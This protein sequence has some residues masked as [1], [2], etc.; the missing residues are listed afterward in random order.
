MPP[1]ARPTRPRHPWRRVASTSWRSAAEA[2]KPAIVN[3]SNGARPRAPTS[4]A[5]TSDA[6]APHAGHSRRLASSSPLALR[7]G[8]AGATAMRNNN[9]SPTGAVMR[10]KYGTPTDTRRS[11]RAST[12]SG[13]T[14]PNN[15]MKANAA[16][17]RLLAKNAPSRDSGES[18]LPG[19]RR[20]SPR[21]K[22]SPTVTTTVIAKNVSS[23]GPTPPS[24][25]ACTDARTPDRVMN[26]PRM[27]SEKV[28]HTSDR[29]HTRNMPR[30]SC[31][32]TEC[33]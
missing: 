7:H 8:N 30:R 16:K 14:V 33:R 2:A 6:T 3:P 27:V 4:T 22:I 11:W 24:L 19:A 31:T 17:T 15:T 29:F 28:A 12:I 20:R 9:V 10:S 18:M 21:Q 25:K 5:N 26:V 23:Q 32:N 13:N 1:L